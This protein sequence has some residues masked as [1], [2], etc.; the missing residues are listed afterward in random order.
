MTLL[1]TALRTTAMLSLVSASLAGAQPARAPLQGFDAY[2]EKAIKD[3]KVPGIAIAIVKD[4]SVVYAKGFGVREVGKPDAVTPRT[5]F[6]IGSSSKAF[7]AA[8]IAMLVDE[9]KLKWDDPAARHVTNFQMY[10][11]YVTRELTVRD[12]LSHRS[13]LSRG[14]LVWYG[15]DLSRDEIVHRARFLAPT[16]SLRST[17]GYQNIMYITAGQAIQQV[18]GKS[19]DDF[20]AERIFAPLGMA[21]SNTSVRDLAGKPDVASPH[22]LLDDTLRAVPW[23]N[24]D[25]AGAAG[26]INSNVLDM[27]KWVRFQLDSARWG[28]KPLIQMG[29]FLAMRT[30][31]TLIPV[32]TGARRVNPHRH[33]R[34]YGLGWFLEDYRGREVVHHGGNIDGMSALVGMMPEERVGF[35]ILT[36]MNGTGVTSALMYRIFDAFLQ[37]PPTDWS[38]VTLR[39]VERGRTRAQEA[40][41]RREASRVAGTSPSL[42]LDRYAGA[43]A[44]SMYGQLQVQAQDGKLHLTIGRAFAGELEHWHFDTWR[45]R[46]RDPMLGRSFVS[47]TLDAEAKVQQVSVDAG[48]G[49]MVFRRLPT[50]PPMAAKPEVK[51]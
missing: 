22:A 28:G 48:G 21:E 14:D 40:Q 8:S 31:H 35:V 39:E 45:A 36:N 29:N 3:W 24:I 18:S 2:V 23:R 38:A 1:P 20:V 43:Y 50:P 5:L 34:S 30:P 15:S 6:A 32:D 26:S 9:G 41:K 25:N 4:T 46:W 44:D 13:G 17:F 12:L 33:F 10:D 27:A 51:R 42:P 7:T 11:P 19:W 47:F 16:W 49:A 37:A